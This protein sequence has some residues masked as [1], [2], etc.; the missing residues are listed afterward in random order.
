MRLAI[1][2]QSEKYIIDINDISRD[3]SAN[4]PAYILIIIKNR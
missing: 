1:S 4:F 2:T 3:I